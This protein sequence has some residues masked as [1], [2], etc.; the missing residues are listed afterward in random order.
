MPSEKVDLTTP[1]ELAI[2]SLLLGLVHRSLGDFEAARRFFEDAVEGHKKVEISTWV[3]GIAWF[4]LAVLD[5]KEMETSEHSPTPPEPSVLRT[6]WLQVLKDAN[7]K[8]DKAL[9]VSPNAVDLSSRLDSRVTMLRDEI[10][11]K[12]G[13]LGESKA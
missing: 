8:L 13:M 3:G 11:L 2:R 7:E 5:L 1:D 10:E 6:R 4:E 12:R 9:G